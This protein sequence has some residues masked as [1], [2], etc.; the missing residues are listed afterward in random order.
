MAKK[1]K[2]P[3]KG[4]N[5][6]SASTFEIGKAILS[7][8]ADETTDIV[9]ASAN[10]PGAAYFE[11]NFGAVS[12][13]YTNEQTVSSSRATFQGE[14]ETVYARVRGIGADG[15]AGEWSDEG[16]ITLSINDFV[17]FTIPKQVGAS[18]IDA[19]AHTIAVT[20]PALTTVTALVA[21]FTTSAGATVAVGETE[22]VSGE[23]END[24][25]SPVVYA[26]TSQ[27]G[28]E[29]EDWTVTVTVLK[30]AKD[31]LTFT[32]PAQVGATVIDTEAKTVL[33]NM[34]DD[35]VVTALVPTFTLSAAASAKVG[36]T[37]QE[38]GVTDNDF[39][40]PVV[41][42]I[43]GEDLSEDDYTVTVNVLKDDG[44]ALLT[45]SLPDETAA[46]VID[47]G[48]KTVTA[49]VAH[50]TD[51][52]AL[53]AT[54]TN[55]EESAVT[56]GGVA[57]VSATTENDFSAPVVY[58]VTAEDETYAD[59]TVTVV[60]DAATN[61]ITAFS[62]PGQE[63]EAVINAET[64]TVALNV[65]YGTSLAALVATFS[66][67][68]GASAAVGATPQESGVTANDFTNPVVY[69][70]TGADA[71]AQNWTV[72]VTVL[73]NTANDVTAYGIAT[74][75]GDSIIDAVNHTVAVLVPNGT[76]VTALVA[77]FTLSANATA[78]VGEVDQ[79]SGVT[80]ND[81]TSPVVYTVTAEDETAQNWT[82][83][84]FV[85]AAP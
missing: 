26:V 30:S 24:F 2:V 64:H 82:M 62:V 12:E 18:V 72:T 19:E 85:E 47:E 20:M 71:V 11:F 25:T 23:T 44:K 75:V 78:K 43:I 6:I 39:S 84:V 4:F 69:A 60:V 77:T 56:V 13:T 22:Q 70:V 42:T 53:V 34:P 14:S 35:T 28:D 51:V 66:L 68:A 57:Q 55:S 52:S 10:C 81:F 67:T 5:Q 63:G 27:E 83:F 40:A 45:F 76:N 33:V 54:F 46:A 37:E 59:Y 61:N 74:Q 8:S 41:Y 36:E 65:P 73:A 9:T 21:S 48:A 29:T 1:I 38:S 79:E 7:L 49:Y 50:D 17:T 80:A 31:I 32:I 16:S 58:R 3:K 15:T